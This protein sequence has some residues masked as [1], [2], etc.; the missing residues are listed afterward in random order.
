MEL[1]ALGVEASRFLLASRPGEEEPEALRDLLERLFSALETFP[2][3]FRFLLEQ[4][5]FA[6]LKSWMRE[7]C[8]VLGL[9]PPSAGCCPPCWRPGTGLCGG[10]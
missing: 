4:R 6:I 3:F 2:G 5:F 1:G 10:A 9:R 8:E 7:G